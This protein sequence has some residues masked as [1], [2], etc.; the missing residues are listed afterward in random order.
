MHYIYSEWKSAHSKLKAL[1]DVKT[2]LNTPN[3]LDIVEVTTVP[4]IINW[5]H[6]TRTV[7]V[8]QVYQVVVDVLEAQYC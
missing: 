3:F 2:E 6:Y 1:E 4:S 8:Y 5:G 7:D